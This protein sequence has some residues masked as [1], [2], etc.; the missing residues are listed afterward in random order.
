MNKEEADAL[1]S[2]ADLTAPVR[3][4]LGYRSTDKNIS[5]SRVALA[6]DAQAMFSAIGAGVLEDRGQREPEE[7]DPARPV[8]PE[9]YLVTTCAEV[10]AVPKVSSSKVQPLLRAL[11][12]TDPIPEVE[13]DDALRKTEP[14]FY[15]FQ[16]GSGDASLTFLR[17]INPLRG[18][19][20]K[21]LAVLDDELRLVNHTVFAFDD[22]AD[23]VVTP[24]HL[25]IFNQ[26]AFAAIFRGQAELEKMT[27]GWVEGIRATTPM[28]DASFAALLA[29]GKSDSRVTKRIES[30]SRRGHLATLTTADLRRGMKKCDLDPKQYFNHA[31]ELV[32]D[33]KSIPEVLK[34]LNEDMFKGVLTDAP[35]E[36]DSKAPRH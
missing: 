5:L 10:G 14:Y 12:D 19:R 3:L 24:T 18:L 6:E 25:L 23:M 16:I 26:T 29:K 33:E 17:K 21:R 11:I 36:V 35:F 34:F 8:S 32:F 4:I 31:G 28:T 1:V 9:T 15:A 27:K 20:K 30:I 2:H 13:G 7:W 22:Y